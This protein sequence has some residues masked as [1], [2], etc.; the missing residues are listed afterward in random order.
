MQKCV[1]L[2]LVIKDLL[3]FAQNV[4]KAKSNWTKSLITK[5][6]VTFIC[7]LWKCQSIS[8]PADGKEIEPRKITLFDG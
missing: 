4:K 1:L 8:F 7:F 6:N 5:E 3:F 2:T